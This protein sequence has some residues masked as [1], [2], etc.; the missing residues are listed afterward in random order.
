MGKGAFNKAEASMVK[1][2]LLSTETAEYF[3]EKVFSTIFELSVT[4]GALGDGE[5]ESA[6]GVYG[7]ASGADGA[8][9]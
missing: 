2:V 3:P 9:V 7:R 8:S 5:G 4:G 6:R 1:F